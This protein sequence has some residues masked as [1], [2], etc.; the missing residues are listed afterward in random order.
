ML[1]LLEAF[2]QIMTRRGGPEDLPDSAFLLQSLVV[3]YLICQL[4]VVVI[5]YGWS[6]TTVLL[7]LADVT[8]LSVFFWAI[9]RLTG[10]EPRFRQT[11]SALLGTGALLSLVQAPL[12]AASRAAPDAA[13]RPAIITLSLLG[14]LAWM[15][16]VHAHITARA[17]SRHF[18]IGMV[19][20]L[21]YFVVSFQV[22]SRISPPVAG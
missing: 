5:M 17:L 13:S 9:L 1:A 2:F 21:A 4:P 19:V 3:I 7:I 16:F 6:G 22:S 12:V 10:H 18:A 14:L 8:L 15:L 20:A 11:L